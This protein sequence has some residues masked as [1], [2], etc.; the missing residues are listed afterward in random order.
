LTFPVSAIDVTLGM[1]W[2]HRTINASGGTVTLNNGG[3]TSQFALPPVS[4]SQNLIFVSVGGG[5]TLSDYRFDFEAWITNL[6][7]SATRSVDGTFTV[8]YG[9]F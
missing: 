5:F 1:G 6:S 3:G 8:S 2:L 9:I 4:S 7:K